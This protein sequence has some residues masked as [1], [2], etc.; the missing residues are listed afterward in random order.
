M[1]CFSLK[2]AF[3]LAYMH[4]PTYMHAHTHNI[5]PRSHTLHTDT[6]M[7]LYVHV[8]RNR[9]C[10]HFTDVAHVKLCAYHM[11]M[12]FDV[13]HVLHAVRA[14]W[15]YSDTCTAAHPRHRTASHRSRS[16]AEDGERTRNPT[17]RTQRASVSGSLSVSVSLCLSLS[18]SLTHARCI[19]VV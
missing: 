18:L 12:M 5:H 4:T 1:F 9:K 14:F 2:H 15:Q 7:Y 16:K 10:I 8:H 13:S 3:G 17:H 11:L 19:K 6:Q